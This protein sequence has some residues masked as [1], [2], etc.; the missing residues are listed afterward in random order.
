MIA[1][2]MIWAVAIGACAGAGA[3][4]LDWVLR[5]HRRPTRWAWSGALL[6]TT[7]LMI[8]AAFPDR[9]QPDDSGAIIASAVRQ[10]PERLDAIGTIRAVL[11]RPARWISLARARLSPLDRPLSVGWL[12]S[13]ALFAAVLLLG[14]RRLARERATWPALQETFSK[15]RRAEDAFVYEPVVVGSFEDAV[16]ATFFNYN[17]QSVVIIDGFG[18]ASQHSTPELRELIAPHLPA[19]AGAGMA[20][21]QGAL[22]RAVR[23]LR[24]ELDVFIVTDQTVGK[25]AGSD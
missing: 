6:G 20:D 11:A 17:L 12:A 9:A 22:S 1:T 2:W 7:I 16:L 10:D 5:A 13:S 15:L 21:M 4:L 24:P 25:L 8:A 14:H 23:L 18:F 19:D 3:A